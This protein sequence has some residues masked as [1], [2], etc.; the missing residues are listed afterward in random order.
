MNLTP[1]ASTVST[2]RVAYYIVGASGFWQMM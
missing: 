2:M 1:E